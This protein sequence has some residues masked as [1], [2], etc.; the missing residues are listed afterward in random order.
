MT[1]AFIFVQFPPA[2][3]NFS[4]ALI[5]HVYFYGQPGMPQT[6]PLILTNIFLGLTVV[7]LIGYCGIRF[8]R[9]TR[10]R[11]RERSV[12]KEE[13][14]VLQTMLTNVG[15]TMQDGGEKIGDDRASL[16]DDDEDATET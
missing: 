2:V 11:N 3:L 13:R 6:L 12:E 10:K 15:I 7:V 16:G 4:S 14:K 1:S 9:E 5:S 8:I